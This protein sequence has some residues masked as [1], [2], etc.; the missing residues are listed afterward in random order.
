MEKEKNQCVDINE[1]DELTKQRILNSAILQ[2]LIKYKEENT[3]LK[4]DKEIQNS[5]IKN[6]EEE[7][8]TLKSDLAKW[9]SP[10]QDKRKTVENILQS[11]HEIKEEPLDYYELTQ[12]S[13]NSE[14]S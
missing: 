10:Y 13:R 9:V 7:N 2:E 8:K 5:I 6:L 12:K 4:H 1:F 11:N 14:Q 3:K